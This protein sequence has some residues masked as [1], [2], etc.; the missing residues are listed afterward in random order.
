MSFSAEE[1]LLQQEQLPKG[2]ARL[3]RAGLF[4][5][6]LPLMQW[7][8]GGVVSQCNSAHFLTYSPPSAALCG[9]NMNGRTVQVRGETSGNFQIEITK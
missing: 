9:W 6:T 3:Q 5:C 4:G 1:R 8:G 2:A 7:G